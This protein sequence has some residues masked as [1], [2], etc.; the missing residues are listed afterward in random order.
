MQ[1]ALEQG[2]KPENLAL[3]ASAGL[4]YIL[5]KADELKLPDE[6]RFDSIENTSE[7]DINK[8]LKWLWKEEYNQANQKLVKFVTETQNQ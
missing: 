5:K 1:L 7:S 6:L 3:G 2:I 4:N 8:L